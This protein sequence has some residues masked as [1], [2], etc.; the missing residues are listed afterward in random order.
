MDLTAAANEPQVLSC[1]MYAQLD[2]TAAATEP[3][4][5]SL[6]L[7]CTMYAQ[8]D[9]EHVNTGMHDFAIMLCRHCAESDAHLEAAATAL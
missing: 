9:P 5:V 8:L 1:T 6:I 4:V 7:S 3:Q 2:L